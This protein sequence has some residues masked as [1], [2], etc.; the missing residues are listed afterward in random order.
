MSGL[1]RCFQCCYGS[2]VWLQNAKKG[3][4]KRSG[5][6][7]AENGESEDLKAEL[8]EMMEQNAEVRLS[9]TPATCWR[10]PAK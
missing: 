7:A 2:P 9:R 1:A 6:R 5:T 4:P 8:A 3:K 10:Q